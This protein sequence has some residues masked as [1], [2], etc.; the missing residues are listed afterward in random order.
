MQL[1]KTVYSP[2]FLAVFPALVVMLFL[3]KTSQEYKLIIEQKKDI[4]NPSFFDDLNSDSI[5]EFLLT[6]KGVPFY[7]ELVFDENYRTYD[8]WN[9]S[10]VI[11]NDLSGAFTGNYDHDR[12][13]EIYVFTHKEDSLFLNI[14][15]FFEP[16]G[17][18]KERIFITKIGY[19]KGEVT[20]L[21]YPAGFYDVNEDGKD[22]LY[23]SIHTGFGLVPRRMYYFDIVSNK[24]QRSDFTGEI[25]QF[26]E[27]FDIDL[28][29]KPEFFGTMG[30]SGNY[31]FEVPYTD[32]SSWLMV[33]NENLKFEFPPIEFKG[34][35][36]ML[37][38]KPFK[39]ENK[40]CYV[41]SL[42]ARGADT[43]RVRSGLFLFSV[44]GVPLKSMDYERTGIRGTAHIAVIRKE[45]NDRLVVCGDRIYELDKNLSVIRIIKPALHTK[46]V[47]YQADIDFDGKKEFLIYSNQEEK[48][49]V[50]TSGF[51]KLAEA[52]LN[53]F[54]Y[55]WL[56]SEKKMKSGSN[57]LY[58]Y[59][60][61][62][63][64]FLRLLKNPYHLAVFF[65]YPASYLAF[66]LLISVTMRLATYQLMQREK[67]KQRL[68]KLQLQGIKSQLDPH[69]TFNTL[70]SVAS[71]IYSEEKEAAYDYMS[72]FTR[73]LRGM[74][75]DTEKIYRSLGEELEFVKTYLELEKLRFG[76]KFSYE[77]TIGAGVTTREQVPKLVLQTFAEN[78]VKHGIMPYSDGG[79]L[80][81]NGEI[82]KNMLKLTIEDNGIG[83]LRSAGKSAS[84]GKGLKLAREF[85]GILNQISKKHI[86][87]KI[88]DL[89]DK[90]GSPA[91][92]RVEVWVPID[93]SPKETWR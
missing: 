20:S 46:F 74:L 11:D 78:S 30:A 13:K 5:S 44:D 10:D 69:F 68:L 92:T 4:E 75:N 66:L 55:N 23:F 22:E 77:I 60:R 85:Y 70:N 1:K 19:L 38:I 64:Y 73:L 87:H 53:I 28:D 65:P 58:I 41:V 50:Y 33:F 48:L 52:G 35:P 80:R 79:I 63:G 91:G 12:F 17:T 16:D 61:G 14:N 37:T 27:M 40:Y 43:S 6:A 93:E 86:T 21:V 54:E 90:G 59:S 15:E 36:N 51:K 26:A 76:D 25:C 56:I 89:Y 2:F 71:L 3:P 39:A 45:E 84:T 57:Q 8:Q 31:K 83:R 88:T 42:E 24:L 49:V 7:H 81:I 47:S 82:E 29:K 9:L 34:Y 72:K 18:R 32:W 67:M 62:K